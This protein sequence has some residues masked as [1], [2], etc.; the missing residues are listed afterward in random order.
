MKPSG[1]RG[2]L[3]VT[4]KIV[5][6]KETALRQ[7][8]LPSQPDIFDFHSLKSNEE[9]SKMSYT[10]DLILVDDVNIQPNQKSLFNHMKNKVTFLPYPE[11]YISFL[12]WLF[13]KLG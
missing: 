6:Y 4:V 2:P 9:D 8:G 7:L 3:D 13:L 1:K 10:V 11:L 5:G 12:V